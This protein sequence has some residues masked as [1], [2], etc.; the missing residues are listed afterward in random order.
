TT[1]PIFAACSPATCPPGSVAL[2]ANVT[3]GVALLPTGCG[4]PAAGDFVLKDCYGAAN[5]GALLGSNIQFNNFYTVLGH[6][7]WQM[8][9]A[10]HFSIRGYGTR[11]HTNGFNGAA[12]Q[13]IIQNSFL[14]T[15]NFINQGISGVFSLNTVLGRKVNEIR[16]S[17]QGETRKR[18]PN[19]NSPASAI[20][21]PA[22]TTAL[23]V[24]GTDCLGNGLTIGSPFS[25]G[26]GTRFYLPI[27][28]DNGKFE[29]ADNFADHVGKHD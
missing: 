11:N 14:N 13:S 19:S 27:N 21:L 18:H 10:N 1:G 29:A 6:W 23:Q 28:N 20:D 25:T 24:P 17:V 8:T 12:G 4:N 15:E 2:P 9:P 22:C 26:I 5:L 16:V 7:D 3:P